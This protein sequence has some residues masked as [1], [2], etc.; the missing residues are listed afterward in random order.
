MMFTTLLLTITLCG[1]SPERH[2]SL[3]D[4][5]SLDFVEGLASMPDFGGD[6][7]KRERLEDRAFDRLHQSI[8]R[9]HGVTVAQV[10][11]ITDDLDLD[12]LEKACGLRV[13]QG[14]PEPPPLH[15]GIARM[16]T[17]RCSCGDEL[18]MA[19]AVTKPEQLRL[20][21]DISGFF[22]GEHK[23]QDHKTDTK[24]SLAVGKGLF[25]WNKIEVLE[26]IKPNDPRYN[27]NG[28][29]VRGIVGGKHMFVHAYGLR[30]C[31]Y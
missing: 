25:W 15:K 26:I 28:P 17:V 24:R 14:D 2:L 5:I 6:Q 30:N 10:E 3:Q 4:K 7:S 29:W 12:R 13:E 16:S 31:E 19:V 27:N 21:D 18:N 23:A 20:V 9:K 22:A 8:A 1:Q 11:A